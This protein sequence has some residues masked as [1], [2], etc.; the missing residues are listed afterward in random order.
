[1]NRKIGVW[2]F[3][4]LFVFFIIV[5][6]KAIDTSGLES[7]VDSVKNNAEAVKSFT[8][9]DKWDYLS[10][11]W[12]ELLLKSKVI[13]SVDSF[14]KKINFIFFLL[15][16]RNYE[17]SLTLFFS[18]ILWIFFFISIGKIMYTFSAF[19]PKVSY[20]IAFLFAVIL[21]HVKVYD[22]IS[23]VIFKIIFYKEGIWGW[24]F[25]FIF[26]VVYFVFLVYLERIIWSVGRAFKTTPK[27][28]AEWD[29]KFE[30]QLFMIRMKGFERSIDEIEKGMRR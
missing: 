11:Q 13:S 17:L 10:E 3:I 26:L 7:G 5:S 22:G 16:G 21:G 18:L 9:K 6:V 28:R 29:E 14:F 4:A 15:L 30:R 2:F 27:Q 8:E 12:K 20:I 24:A 23:L 1:M 25:F 19:S